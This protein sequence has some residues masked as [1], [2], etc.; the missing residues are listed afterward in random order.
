MDL[1]QAELPTLA[2]M[3]HP[4]I[5]E[6]VTQCATTVGMGQGFWRPQSFLVWKNL[7]LVQVGLNFSASGP[8]RE[9]FEYSKNLRI[10][11]QTTN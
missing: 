8:E 4:A 5:I 2:E 1:Q 11:L 3:L 6:I 10:V 9:Y 7:V